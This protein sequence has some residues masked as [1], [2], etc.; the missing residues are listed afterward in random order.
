MR[1]DHPRDAG[2]EG[3]RLRHGA[4]LDDAA[5]FEERAELSG[6]VVTRS[7]VHILMD[8]KGEATI[9]HRACMPEV[10]L[11]TMWEQFYR[12]LA[13]DITADDRPC[14]DMCCLQRSSEFGGLK[15]CVR[16][17]R[18]GESEPG[19]KALWSLLLEIEHLAVLRERTAQRHCILAPPLDIAVE[20][21]EL[22]GAH[23]ALQLRGAQV[24]A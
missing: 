16:A 11:D 18:H 9:H 17:H 21:R 5:A 13:G 7:G 10:T 24:V 3:L 2:D 15:R 8:T 12:R 23:R 14:L 6:D 22:Y 4:P 19:M 1:A 20:L